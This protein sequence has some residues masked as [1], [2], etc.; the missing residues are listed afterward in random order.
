MLIGI[1]FLLTVVVFAGFANPV[2]AYEID[3]DYDW[4][5]DET[6]Y[7]DVIGRYNFISNPYTN[8]AHEGKITEGNVLRYAFTRFTQKNQTG[9]IVFGPIIFYLQNYTS[10]YKSYNNDDVYYIITYTDSG[11]STIPRSSVIVEIGPPGAQ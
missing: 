5:I 7:A 3:S 11:Y 9:D 10:E 4:S 6:A 2:L 8:Q 1:A